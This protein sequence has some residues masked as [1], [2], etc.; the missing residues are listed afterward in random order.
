MGQYCILIHYHELGL[1]KDNKSWFEKIFQ[2]NIR[3]HLG[4]LE[5]KNINTYA[6]RVFI[7]GVNEKKWSL[8]QAKLKNV[9]GLKNATLMQKIDAD[10][11]NIKFIAKKISTNLNFKSFRITTKRQDKGFKFTSH[12]INQMIGAAVQE[13]TNKP[14]SLKNSEIGR[15]HV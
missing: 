2:K 3:K 13:K 11:E 12:Q 8:Y 15:A 6:S 9:M 4:E 7:Y 5:F 14:V 1:K 10:V